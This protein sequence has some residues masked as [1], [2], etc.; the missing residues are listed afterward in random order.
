MNVPLRLPAPDVNVA[1]P[2]SPLALSEVIGWPSG[3]AAV[4]VNDSVTFSA[5]LWVAGAETTGAR[6]TEIE[7]VAGLLASAFP[8][9]N[10]TE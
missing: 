4:T 3:S 5:A 8:A 10:V 1:P 2:G 9:W 7:V 6:S